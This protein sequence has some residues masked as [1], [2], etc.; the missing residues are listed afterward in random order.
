[1]ELLAT[2]FTT[3]LPMF[4]Q[5]MWLYRLLS[6]HFCLQP[7]FPKDS[8]FSLL[9]KSVNLDLQIIGKY[10]SD[11]LTSKHT[12]SITDKHHFPLNIMVW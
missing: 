8:V 3:Y 9:T 5:D 2:R 6:K 10:I 1:M 4:D 12:L 7:F 11:T